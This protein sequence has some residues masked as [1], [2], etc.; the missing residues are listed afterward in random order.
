M[1]TEVK[2]KWIDALIGGDYPQAKR[3]LKVGDSFC[4]IG[5]LC[6]LYKKETG[7]GKW[8]TLYD[9][10]YGFVAGKAVLESN[11]IP[12]EVREW[13]DVEKGLYI[14]SELAVLNDS[15]KTFSEISEVIKE[16]L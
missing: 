3:Q 7:K 1:N 4:C 13:A 5:V 14:F 10:A 16:K 12:Q 15:G 8:V 2:Q 9:D 11:Y 6:D